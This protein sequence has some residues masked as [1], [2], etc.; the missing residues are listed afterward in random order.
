MSAKRGKSRPQPR[1]RAPSTAGWA[2]LSEAEATLAF[3]APLA[4]VPSPRVKEQLLTRVRG[5]NATVANVTP[6]GW[7]FESASADAGWRGASFPGVRFKTLSVDERRDVVVVLIEMA[8]GARFPDHVHDAGGDE[9]IVISG[10][11]ITAGRLMRAGDYY[12]AAE[13]TAHIDT[14]SP[15]GCTALVSLTARAW[16]KWREQMASA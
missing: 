10:D 15:S 4:A 6:P 13:G 5:A 16:K 14:V 11:V 8:A 3:A 12:I 7:R 1:T 2:S 9:G